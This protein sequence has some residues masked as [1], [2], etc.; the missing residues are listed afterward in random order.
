M[1]NIGIN[2][3]MGNMGNMC[4]TV[5]SVIWV[6][7]VLLVL[8]VIWVILVLLGNINTKFPPVGGDIFHSGLSFK[9]NKINVVALIYILCPIR[10]KIVAVDLYNI[11]L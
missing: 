9:I 11:F 5:I 1:G 10:Y 4:H 7:W 2:G 3:S 8:L 6:I